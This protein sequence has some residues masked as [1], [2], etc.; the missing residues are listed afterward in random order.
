MSFGDVR[1]DETVDVDSVPVIELLDIVGV[2][3]SDIK[4]ELAFCIGDSSFID[5]KAVVR[6][7]DITEER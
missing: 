6:L 3:V 7:V 1:V 4:I 5:V 2:E